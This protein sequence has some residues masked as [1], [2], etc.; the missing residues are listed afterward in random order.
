M[1][2]F[3]EKYFER[4]QKKNIIGLQKGERPFLYSFWRR[5]LK[6]LLPEGAKI[7]EVG[8]G[9]G[10]FLKWLEQQYNIVGMDISSE[11]LK[12]AKW[13]TNARLILGDAQNLPF[14]SRSFSAVIAF[15]LIE[16]LEK[17]E[18]FLAEA[19][20][21]LCVPG[22]LIISTPN[23]ESFGNKIKGRREDLKGLPYE[24]RMDEWFGWRDYT[25]ISIK[26]RNEW[27]KIIQDIGFKILKDGTDTLWDVPYFKV[28]PVILQ[29]IFFI[30][31]HWVLTYFGGFFSWKYGENIIFIALKEKGNK[32]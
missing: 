1:D 11:A 3:R 25:H 5:K 15:D 20:R 17:P 18:E 23:P 19:Y 4:Y 24:E 6:K 7:L 21:M 22:F 26:L 31:I 8:C 16:H 32:K 29:R 30:G 2:K 9:G 14:E 12:L 28:V 27:R 13:K 10:Y